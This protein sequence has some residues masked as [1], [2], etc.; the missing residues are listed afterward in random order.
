MS[1]HHV[2]GVLEDDER[3]LWATFDRAVSLAD[4]ERARLTFAK[5]TDPGW[6]TR[7]FAPAALQSMLVSAEELDFPSIASHAL[8]RAAEF[9]PDWIP[10]T[11]LVLEQNTA[12]ALTELIRRG[13]YDALVATEAFFSH[14]RKMQRELRRLD[15]RTFC[16]PMTHTNDLSQLETIGV[17]R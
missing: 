2:L 4:A 3:R 15:L 11:T 12:C 9:V 6:L 5:T 7:W 13:G 17:P 10:V 14:H 1:V 8:A 16:A